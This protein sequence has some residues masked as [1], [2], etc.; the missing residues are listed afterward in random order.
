LAAC[1]F[2]WIFS[3]DGSRMAQPQCLQRTVV[4]ASLLGT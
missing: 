3:G 2:A 4:P 1:F